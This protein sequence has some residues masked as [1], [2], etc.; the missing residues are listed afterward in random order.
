MMKELKEEFTTAPAEA[1]GLLEGLGH[2]LHSLTE[3]CPAEWMGTIIKLWEGLGW[4]GP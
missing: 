1:R 2:A 3:G 4:K